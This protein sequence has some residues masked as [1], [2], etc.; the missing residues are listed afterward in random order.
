MLLKDRVLC[1]APRSVSAT[2]ASKPIVVFADGC[3]EPGSDVPAGVGGVMFCPTSFG[4]VQV[5]AFGAVVPSMLLD[6]WHA[7]GK[8]H[9]IGQVEMYA[10]LLARSCWADV[11][12]GS[13][14]IF[15]VDHSGVH[16]RLVK[17]GYLEKAVVRS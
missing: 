6:T 12:D 2:Q 4:S 16:K 3:F 14:V 15:F 10:V 17:R 5:R 1:G 7:K 13:R 8:R 9:L 11:L